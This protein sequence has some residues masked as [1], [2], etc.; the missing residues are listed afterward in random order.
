MRDFRRINQVDLKGGWIC[1]EGY[2]RRGCPLVQILDR[3][4]YTIYS[5]RTTWHFQKNETGPCHFP[6][7]RR[8]APVHFPPSRF[9]PLDVLPQDVSPRSRVV[10]ALSRFGLESFRSWVVSAWVVS[11]LGRFGQIWWVVSA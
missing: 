9:A 3:Y 5:E 6:P 1:A 10:S 8:F 2:P 7:P 4:S 11:A